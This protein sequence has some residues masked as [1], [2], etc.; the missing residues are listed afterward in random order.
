MTL[1]EVFAVIA[2]LL[3]LLA[4]MVRARI[5]WIFGG[6]SN[7]LYGVLCLSSALYAETML[8]LV[9]LVLA[10]WGWFK[11]ADSVSGQGMVYR[12]STNTLLVQLVLTGLFSLVCGYLLDRLSDA[13]MPFLDSAILCFSLLATRLTIDRKIENWLLWLLIDVAAMYLYFARDLT[14]SSALYLLYALLCIPGYI[15]WK[16]TLIPHAHH[17][18]N[19]HKRP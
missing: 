9:Y 6:V 2:S 1:V 17:S 11:W 4:A 8:Q 3:Y 18:Q 14:L 7:I 15:L 16:R 13:F 19:R 12:S 5:C 10:I